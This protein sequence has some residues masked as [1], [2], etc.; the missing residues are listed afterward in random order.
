M[1]QYMQDKTCNDK[2]C[3]SKTEAE[4]KK[5]A[6]MRKRNRKLRVYQCDECHYW[7]LTSHNDNYIR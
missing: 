1:K 3:Y 4:K 7:H 2:K 5:I 6:Y